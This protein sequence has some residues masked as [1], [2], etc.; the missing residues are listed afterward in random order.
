MKVKAKTQA[1]AAKLNKTTNESKGEKDIT[2]IIPQKNVRSLNSSAILTSETWRASNAE[3]WET[4]QRH[5]F[6]GSRTFENKQGVGILVNNKWRKHTNWTDDISERPISTS[7]TINK[8]HVL[9]MSVLLLPLGICGPPRC[10]DV[11][12]N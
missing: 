6:M 10:K 12:N 4:Q 5:R 7:M 1:T 2:F 3:I 11:Q 9:L 8:Q